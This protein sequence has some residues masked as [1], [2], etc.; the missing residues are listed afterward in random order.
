MWLILCDLWP[1][2]RGVVF[3]TPFQVG[4]NIEAKLGSYSQHT[5]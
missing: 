2:I 4:F 1:L 3:I 5:R